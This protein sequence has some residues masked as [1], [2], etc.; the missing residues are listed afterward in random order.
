MDI[1]FE[2]FLHVL[3]LD[4]QFLLAGAVYYRVLPV[5]R[6]SVNV[7]ESQKIKRFCLTVLTVLF[8]KSAEW[9]DLALVLRQFQIEFLQPAIQPI[10]RSKLCP[11]SCST[12]SSGTHYRRRQSF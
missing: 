11:T 8:R 5:P 2:P 10:C 9:Y 12:V 7:G 3:L 6:Y 4:L 1:L